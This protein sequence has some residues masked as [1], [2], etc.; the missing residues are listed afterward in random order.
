MGRQNENPTKE[1]HQ[2]NEADLNTITDVN[3]IE[4]AGQHAKKVCLR[5]GFK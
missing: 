1:T 3:N 2:T 4:S 5:S